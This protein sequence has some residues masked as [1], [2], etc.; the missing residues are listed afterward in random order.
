VKSAWGWTPE[1]TFGIWRHGAGWLKPL[2]ASVPY[3]TVVILALTMYL[4][5]SKATLP[6]GVLFD[7]PEEEMSDAD[8]AELVALVMPMKKETLVFFDDSRYVLGDKSSMR[9]F[10]RHLGERARSGD[11]KSLLVLADR[12][13]SCEDLMRLAG[14]AR[15]SGVK[16]ALFAEKRSG[17]EE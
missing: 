5:S 4:A 9:S 13:V 10:A 16:R 14:I 3:L 1:R 7:L 2:M 15:K 17:V 11:P 6:R 12:R 8:A